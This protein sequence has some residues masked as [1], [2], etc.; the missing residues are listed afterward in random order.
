LLIHNHLTASQKHLPSDPILG[1]APFK[2][3]LFCAFQ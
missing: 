2:V 3:V 1:K